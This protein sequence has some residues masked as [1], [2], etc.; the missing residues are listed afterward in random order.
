MPLLEVIDLHKRYGSTVALTGVSFH[1]DE[2][3]MFG[4]LGPNGAGKTTLL[5]ILSC[6]LE[7]SSGEARILGRKVAANDREL[8]RQIAIVPQELALYGELS[9]RENLAFFGGLYGLAGKALQHRCDE[10]LEA[11]GLSDRAADRVETY[12][13]GMK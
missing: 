4:L 11:I 2:G 3:E 8:R 6:L 1:V 12:S 5:S 9:A 7:A 13:G 10:V